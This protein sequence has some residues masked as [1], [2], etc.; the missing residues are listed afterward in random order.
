MPNIELRNW[1]FEATEKCLNWFTKTNKNKHF[2]INAAPGAG[3]TICASVIA[4]K[5]IENGDIDRVIIIAPRAEVVRQWAEEFHFVTQRHMSRIT[6]VDADIESYGVDLCAT[7]SAI[8]NL[9]DG[10]QRVCSSSKTLVI[11]DEHHHAAV[12]AA[13]G[14]GADGAF[15]DAK[16]TLVLTGTPMRSDGNETVWLAFDDKGQINQPSDGMYT[17]S[18]GEAVGLGYCRPVAFHRHEGQ[19]TVS[20]AG[21]PGI[22]VSSNGNTE[23]PENLKNIRGLKQAVDFYKLACTRKYLRDN[24]TPDLNSY[25]ATLLKHGIEKLNEQRLTIPNAGG[26]VI[27][28]NIE[29]AEYM[30]EILEKLEGERPTIVHS[31]LTNSEQRIAAFRNTSQKWIVSVAM[32]SE[33]VDIKRLRVM[34]YLPN[35]RTELAFRQAVGR[36]VRSLGKKD[37]SSAYVIMPIL[38]TLET[39]AKRIEDEMGP[40]ANKPLQKPTSKVCPSCENECALTDKE[41]PECGHEFPEPKKQYMTC[42]SCGALNPISNDKCDSCGTSFKTEFTIELR[43]AYRDGIIT[44][45]MELTNDEAIAGEKLDPSLDKDILSSGQET[46]IALWSQIPPSAKAKFINLVNQPRD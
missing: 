45:G 43:D 20:C 34:V 25:Q 12:A 3:K 22:R 9:Q 10:F 19:F 38:K 5:L 8:A 27:A 30:A 17:L 2:V 24:V 18:Y 15:K 28:P 23:I 40:M 36:V 7:W 26:L 39:Y 16:Y 21:G 13:W 4:A 6:G 31:N 41:C 32:I 1:Q 44:R 42:D 33:G 29:M 35:A 46:L 11:C 37:M 14:A